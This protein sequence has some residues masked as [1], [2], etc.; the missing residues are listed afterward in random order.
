MSKEEQLLEYWR[1][2]SPEAQD[3]VLQL[4][5]TLKPQPEFVPQT[6]LGKKLWEIRQRIIAS[7]VPLL[8]DEELEQELAER[9]GDF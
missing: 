4:A 9:R 2:L 5:Q 7:G 6:P 3:R 1:E 8:S